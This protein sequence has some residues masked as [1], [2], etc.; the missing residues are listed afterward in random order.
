MASGWPPRRSAGSA[1]TTGHRSRSTSPSPGGETLPPRLAPAAGARRAG[2]LGRAPGPVRAAD[3]AP[4]SSD[5]DH[6]HAC[7][8]ADGSPALCPTYEDVDPYLGTIDLIESL[9]PAEM[10]SGHWP[11]RSGA[12]VLAFLDDSRGFVERVDG[13]LRARMAE[14]ATL[15]QLCGRFR[16]RPGRGTPGRRCCASRS[17][18]TCA[19][20]SP[21]ARWRRSGRPA[22]CRATAYARRPRPLLGK[23][24]WGRGLDRSIP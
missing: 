11:M 2:P 8:A 5:A 3:R 1:P 4:V 9:A 12:E 21:R 15:A 20:W 17:P 14:P 13:V 24:T 10:H 22:R 16:T 6:W 19:D 18:A 23:R 7:P